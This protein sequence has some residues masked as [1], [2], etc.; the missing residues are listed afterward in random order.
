MDLSNAI[1][2]NNHMK[3]KKLA[4]ITI[5]FLGLFL[6]IFTF[7]CIENGINI[8]RDFP[9]EVAT[10]TAAE[11]DVNHPHTI[12]NIA[13]KHS[14]KMTLNKASRFEVVITC[15]IDKQKLVEQIKSFKDTSSIVVDSLQVTE[16]MKVELKYSTSDFEVLD[17][18]DEINGRQRVVIDSSSYN[19]LW[20]WNVTPLKVQD[21]LPLSVKVWGE[22]GGE[23]FSIP[24]YDA[25]IY[26]QSEEEPPP[27]PTHWSVYALIGLIVLVLFTL[28]Y[29]LRKRKNLALNL[30]A[31]KVN[32]IKKLIT[33]NNIK[34]AIEEL[35]SLTPTSNIIVKK[36]LTTLS[37][38]LSKI[39]SEKTMNTISYEKYD[40]E[41]SKI[42]QRVLKML[43]R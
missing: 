12:G 9:E 37:A 5:I 35:S 18:Q 39:E 22:Y 41:L 28:F 29:L 21:S 32:D 13:Y 38:R 20:Q 6:S 14:E 16:Y 33:K 42:R 30:P 19:A 4:A 36:E 27:P 25:F 40:L 34:Q 2:M 31:N 15:E 8:P 43:G 1:I 7:S 23:K 24:V 10:T 11:T 3:N 17:Y 26:V